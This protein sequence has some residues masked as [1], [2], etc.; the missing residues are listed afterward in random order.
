MIDP[1]KCISS[2]PV[3]DS[4]SA[5]LSSNNSL[6]MVC[7]VLSV[8]ATVSLQIMEAYLTSLSSHRALVTVQVTTNILSLSK[9]VGLAKAHPSTDSGCKGGSTNGQFALVMTTE[10]NSYGC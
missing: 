8:T 10:V 1:A 4:S 7:S 2:A 6:R 5:W 9:D 3:M